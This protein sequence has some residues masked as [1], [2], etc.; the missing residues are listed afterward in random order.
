M[1]LAQIVCRLLGGHCGMVHCGVLDDQQTM[2]GCVSELKMVIHLIS[3]ELLNYTLIEMLEQ[4]SD[5]S[6]SDEIELL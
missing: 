2:N 6:A 3:D 1:E 4:Y 5:V